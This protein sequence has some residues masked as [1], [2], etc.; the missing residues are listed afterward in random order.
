[1][2]LERKTDDAISLSGC[3]SENGSGGSFQIF[4]ADFY[5]N[6]LQFKEKNNQLPIEENVFAI[7]CK[8]EE[9]SWWSDRF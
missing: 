3:K 1:M 8:V 5:N 9:K 7:F 2:G 6:Y 4:I